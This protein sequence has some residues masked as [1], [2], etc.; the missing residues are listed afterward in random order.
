MKLAVYGHPLVVIR[1]RPGHPADPVVLVG[2]PYRWMPVSEARALPEDTFLPTFPSSDA[3]YRLL[4]LLP[5]GWWLA[6][7]EAVG[8][9][10]KVRILRR[11]TV[12]V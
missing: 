9:M 10:S 8:P 3:A 7:I 11:K 4:R 5:A 1:D 12:G 2:V 6:E